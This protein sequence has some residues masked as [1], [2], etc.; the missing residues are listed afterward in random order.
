MTAKELIKPDRNTIPEE[1]FRLRVKR[2]ITGLE[3]GKEGSK[4]SIAAAIKE[5]NNSHGELKNVVNLVQ[6]KLEA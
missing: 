5:L 6:N 3:K 2:L 4:E 1:E